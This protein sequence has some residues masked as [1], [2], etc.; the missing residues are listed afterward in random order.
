MNLRRDSVTFPARCYRLGWETPIVKQYGIRDLPFYILTDHKM[1][2]QALG[3]DW[4]KDIKPKMP[5]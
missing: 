4:D 3:T 2:I 5:K 1:R